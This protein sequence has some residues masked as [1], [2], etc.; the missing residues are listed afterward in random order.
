M[1]KS[2]IS[3]SLSTEISLGYKKIVTFRGHSLEDL[4]HI[5]KKIKEISASGPVMIHIVT[6][7][8][9]GYPLA[10]A[11]ADDTWYACVETKI[12]RQRKMQTYYSEV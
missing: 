11:A 1:E 12:E 5:F 6:R 10:E 8:G 3:H 2:E 9:I 4:V 7:K